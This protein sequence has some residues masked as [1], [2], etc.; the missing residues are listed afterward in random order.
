MLGN[1]P[2]ALKKSK[3][4]LLRCC[5]CY[6]GLLLHVCY[7]PPNAATATAAAVFVAQAGKPGMERLLAAILVQVCVPRGCVLISLLCCREIDACEPYVKYANGSVISLPLTN[8]FEI[9][10]QAV[11]TGTAPTCHHTLRYGLTRCSAVFSS[12][13]LHFLLDVVHACAMSTQLS[14]HFALFAKTCWC[15]VV[16]TWLS[17]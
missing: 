14:G 11:V 15:A 10:A 1:L 7:S 9:D 12:F 17:Q 4:L 16:Q 6:S 2:P 13:R 5:C 3:H 8:F